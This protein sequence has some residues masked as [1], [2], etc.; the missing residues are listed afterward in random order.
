MKDQEKLKRI[1]DRAWMLSEQEMLAVNPLTDI[2]DIQRIVDV[3]LNTIH[4]LK[5][6]SKADME[7]MDIYLLKI[8]RNPDYFPFT[9]KLLFGIDIFPF[10]HII[11]KE[12][13]KRP[14]PM[15]I[16]G[17]GA[18]K[19]YILALYSMLRLLF[20]QGC[21]IAIIGKVF[22]QSKVIF[23]YM[24]GLWANG[25]IYRD[26]CGVGKGRNNRDQGPRRD[27]D[28]CEMIVGESVAMALPLGTGE[29]IRGQ[30]ANYTVCDEF[31]SIREDIYQNVVRG[32]SSVSSN[33]SEKVHRQAKIRLMKQL[34]VWTDEDEAQE[35]K[36]LRSNQNI[37]SGTAYYSF[38]HFYKTWFNYKR[39]IESNGDKN[40]L[41]QIFQGP[42]PDGFDWRDYSI[43]R[44]PVEI[45]PPGFMDAKQI[46]SARINSTK[47]NY[48]I[49][50][51]ATFATDSDGFFKRSLI[52]S[53]VSGNPSSPIVLPS[54]E[55]LFHASLLGDSSVQ[56]VMAID[57]ASERDNFAVIILALYPDHRR[58]VYCWTT[59]RSSFKEKMKSGIV[60]EKDFY[61]YCCRKIRNLAK[62]FPNMV[63]IAL[64]SQGG[65]IAIEEGLQDTN[66]LQDSEKAIYKVID[67]L[68]RKDSDDKSGEHIL[69]MINFADPNWVV[70]ANHGLRKDLEDKTLLFP[71]FDPISLTLAQEEDMATGRVN[72]YDTLED[73]VMDIEEL[74]DEL[75]SIVHVHTPSGRDRWDTP[76][77]RDPDG[78]KSRTRKDRY[79]ALL[80]ANMVA[81]A[82]Q[83]I[84][85]QDEYT[86]TGGFAR[87]VASQ[88]AEDK[89]MYIGPEWFK[90]ATN[91]GSG[92]GIVVPTRCNNTIE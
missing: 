34:G 13:W 21:K 29:K 46:T 88:N 45:L 58:I 14:F 4:P 67:P 36:I 74:K 59:T 69:S 61:S 89:E 23:E 42:V 54:G 20:T 9:C 79:S 57:P 56:H 19:S 66:R 86:H 82:F 38:N 11:L 62:M 37:V 27:I 17:R 8:M 28:R 85:V 70:E 5:N 31:A 78:K 10:Q 48:L 91:H 81:R 3:P 35:S 16:A 26:I 53:C 41:E 75:S 44:L 80:M 63:R 60:N 7:R 25:V 12:L 64:D 40:L 72:M 65:G 87:H 92:Y 76:E 18:G 24:E 49:E 6:I 73:C 33:P 84:E 22:R 83:R 77:S 90:K 32:F 2:N 47:A 1:I 43:I 30:R 15:I 71:Y 52:E 50:Y 68:K 39:I 51:G 55:V